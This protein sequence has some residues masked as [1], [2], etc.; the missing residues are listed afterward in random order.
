MKNKIIFCLLI[1]V[2]TTGYSQT[3]ERLSAKNAGLAKSPN[4]YGYFNKGKDGIF[5]TELTGKGAQQTC[6]LERLNADLSSA[7]SQKIPLEDKEEFQFIEIKK[8]K[9]YFFTTQYDGRDKSIFL[10]I[11]DFTSGKT[12]TERK[13]MSSL[14][15]DPF[16]TTGRNFPISFSPDET[17]MMI[18]SSFQWPKK[19][20]DVKAEIYDLA[21]MK[22][23][24]T[25]S[26]PADYEGEMIKTGSYELTDQGDVIFIARN[27]P[28]DKKAEIRQVL[29]SYN[30]GNKSFKFAE[31]PFEKK[32]IENSRYF[33]KNGNYYF[34]GVFKD[35]YSKKDDKENK[36]GVFCIAA[37][38]KDMKL[39]SSGFE[40]FPA[41]VDA[42]LT[43]K[44]GQRRRDLSEKEFT[45]KD[46][47]KTSD[48]FYLIENLTYT[49]E[50][51]SGNTTTYK[52]YSREYIVSKFNDAGKLEFVKMIPKNTTNK[53]Y[54]EDIVLRN[55]ELYIFYCEHPK[56]L[57]KYTLDNFDPK[58]YDD[59]GDLRGPVAVCVKV[60]AKGNLSREELL[61]NET[62][63]YWPGSGI[64]VKEGKDLAVMEIQKDEY[65]LEVFRIK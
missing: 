22:V 28:K 1:A 37:D 50:V 20:Q 14:P 34:T 16:G 29:G 46:I 44:D 15:T 25:I 26:I 61:T 36:A 59:V 55:G 35:N 21:T 58:E 51:T 63:C 17:K 24:S 62:W 31:L 19:P 53:M 13:K 23:I 43:Y 9:I 65:L 64:I 5:R 42:K 4:L 8:D 10:K 60:D 7:F 57:E 48:G 11:L 45:S 41:D 32:K 33:L 18:V 6:L 52:P 54:G 39:I 40:Y 38:P 3:I 47:C 56:N 30:A 49:S 27:E 12:T 2:V